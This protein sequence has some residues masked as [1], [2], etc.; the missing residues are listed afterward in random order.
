MYILAPK[1]NGRSMVAENRIDDA[2]R[3]E[4]AS[5]NE[6]PFPWNGNEI[7]ICC[8]TH[9]MNSAKMANI[10]YHNDAI[11]EGNRSLSALLINRNRIC[12]SPDN[13]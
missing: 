11:G 12:L 13:G 3:S 5:D 7:E 8:R 4:E 10:K 1:Y 6:R 9:Y 2:S